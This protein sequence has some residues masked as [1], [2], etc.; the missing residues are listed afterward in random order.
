MT[1]TKRHLKVKSRCSKLYSALCSI[2]LNSSNVGNILWSWILR[3]YRSSRKEKE[4]A[5]CCV[6]DLHKTRN[7]AFLRRSGAMMGKKCKKKVLLFCQSKPIGFLLSSLTSQSFLLKL[8]IMHLL[9]V[10]P[11]MGVGVGGQP[12]GNL[13]FSGLK[14]S[15]SH[16]WVSIMN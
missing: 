14:M 4:M 12:T 8:P 16:P 9:V 13:T 11:R 2:L 5:L 3:L 1:A 15:N 10:C 7:L 6:H